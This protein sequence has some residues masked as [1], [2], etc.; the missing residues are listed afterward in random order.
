MNIDDR[1][2][3]IQNVTIG[4]A[5]CNMLLSALKLVAGILGRSSA[6]IAD[7]VHSLS[8]LVSDI[9]VVVFARLAAKGKDKGHDYGHGKF[10]TLATLAVSILL[11][12]VGA[13]MIVSSV[14]QVK[15][16]LGGNELASPGHIA[17]IAAILSIVVKEILYQWTARVGKKVSSPVMIANAWHHRTDALSSLGSLFGIGGA[18][19]L[20]GKWTILDPLVGG[21]ISIIII[22]VAV[23]MSIPT[24]SELTDASLPDETES[25]ISYIIT[26]I[27]GVK[28]VHNLKSRQCGHYSIVEAHIV[29]S[30]DMSVAEAHDITVKAEDKLRDEF[31]PEMQISLHVEPSEDAR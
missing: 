20:G 19:L 21:V 15:S 1:T 17:L 12:I 27:D 6:M 18:I 22:V 28:D 7:A 29:V 4:G 9:I 11:L 3:T 31:G 30:P 14:T 25:V 13:K 24:L 2:R 16:V 23:K 5:V 8:D 10:E 26:S